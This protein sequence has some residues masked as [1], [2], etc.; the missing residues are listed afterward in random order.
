LVP[1]S[2]TW[3][4]RRG[5]RAK[6]GMGKKCKTIFHCWTSGYFFAVQENN[7]LFLTLNDEQEKEFSTS[8]SGVDVRIAFFCDFLKKQCYD[9]IFEK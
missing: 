8:Q 3:L 1:V 7:F 9:H 4:L 5:H 6:K 2:Q